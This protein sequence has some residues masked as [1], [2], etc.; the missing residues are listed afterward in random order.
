M[1]REDSAALDCPLVRDLRDEMHKQKSFVNVRV[2]NVVQVADK[3]H[4]PK[5]VGLHEHPPDTISLLLG[6]CRADKLLPG[7]RLGRTT[8]VE[9]IDGPRPGVSHVDDVEHRPILAP[10]GI[11]VELV[12]VQSL[13]VV[14]GTANERMASLLPKGIEDREHLGH[15]IGAREEAR[16]KKPLVVELL[17]VQTCGH[18]LR[19]GAHTHHVTGEDCRTAHERRTIS[20]DDFVGEV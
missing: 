19:D 3:R 13:K 4:V 14:C 8:V 17:A 7:V 9:V 12:A 11:L 2:H 1:I 18:E 5:L 16:V 15:V 20:L 6:L 10:H